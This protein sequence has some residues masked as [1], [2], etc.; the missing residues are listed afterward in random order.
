MA[1]HTATPTAATNFRNAKAEYDEAAI[2]AKQL[3][4]ETGITMWRLIQDEEHRLEVALDAWTAELR[5]GN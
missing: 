4:E 2:V 5:A 1:R 3:H